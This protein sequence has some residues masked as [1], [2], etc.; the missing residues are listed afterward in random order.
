MQPATKVILLAAGSSTRMGHPKALLKINEKPLIKYQVDSIHK[1]KKTPIVVLGQLHKEIL[2][3]LP[4]IAEKAII[5]VNTNS[6]EGQFSSLKLGLQKVDCG[7]NSF[8]LPLDTPAPEP[9]IWQSLE[10][11]LSSYQVVVPRFE[12]KGGHP[13][14]LSSNFISKLKQASIP[15]KDQR[16][17]FQIRS[18]KKGELGAVS[19]S[20]SSILVDLDTPEDVELY[21]K[22]L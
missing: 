3:A 16:L 10:N 17:D 6:H 2:S 18:L 21:F 4:E 13:V 22:C 12:G 14:L 15:E 7:E 19:V 1:L 5:L 11:K 20:T 8:V 9:G